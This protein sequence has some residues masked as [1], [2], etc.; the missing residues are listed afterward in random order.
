MVALSGDALYLDLD[1]AGP[2][3]LVAISETSFSQSGNVIQ[4]VADS[5]GV[6]THFLI[7]T[8]EGEDLAVRKR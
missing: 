7:H 3:H 2:Q 5:A 6:I 8:V 1:R 4:F